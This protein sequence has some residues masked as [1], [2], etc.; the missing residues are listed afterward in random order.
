[1]LDADA[2]PFILTHLGDD[3]LVYAILDEFHEVVGLDVDQGVV[4]LEEVLELA[5]DQVELWDFAD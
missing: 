2:C 5:V 3:R 1:M 4:V